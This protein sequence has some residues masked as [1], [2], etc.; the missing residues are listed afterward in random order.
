MHPMLVPFI[1]LDIACCAQFVH[2]MWSVAAIIWVCYYISLNNLF[3]F[4]YVDLVYA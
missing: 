3:L 2:V 4:V 1:L